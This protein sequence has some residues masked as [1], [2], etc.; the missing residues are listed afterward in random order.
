MTLQLVKPQAREEIERQLHFSY[1]QLNTYLLCPAKYGH[2]YVFATPYETK[3][4]AL[5][6]GKAIHKAGETYYVNLKDTVEIIPVEQMIAVFES[7]FD[8]E[9]EKTEVEIT[10]KDG[11]TLG[12]LRDQGKELLKIYHTEV[13]PQK[14]MAVEFPFKVKVPDI[15]NGNRN[16]PVDLV[17]YFDL[18]ECDAQKTYVVVELKTSAQRFSSLRLE[19]DLQATVYS[20][21]MAK[22]KV[23]TSEHSTLIRYDVL[24]KTK[25]PAFE[26]YYV[27][28]TE[29]DHQRL[30]HLVNHVLRAIEHKIFYRQTGWQCG[31]CQFKKACFS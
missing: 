23:A 16:L 27:T 17:G 3:P 8:Q 10:C 24:V 21:A 13:N 6:F 7:V 26:H 1:S 22:L 29:A 18:I 25:K 20:Y 28:R 31:D 14:I 12:T 5:L 2:Q 19:Y 11:E 9:I 4:A 15:I 30:I